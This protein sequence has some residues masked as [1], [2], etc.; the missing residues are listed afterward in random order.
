MVGPGVIGMAAESS[1]STESALTAAMPNWTL[2]RSGFGDSPVEAGIMALVR[3]ALANDSDGERAIQVA[4]AITSFEFWT[5]FTRVDLAPAELTPLK[6][7]IL[8][9]ALKAARQV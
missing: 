3:E 1:G 9:C 6:V 7:K 4:V 2:P 5:R 8:E